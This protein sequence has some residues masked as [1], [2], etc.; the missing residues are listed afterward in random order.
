MSELD[1]RECYRRFQTALTAAYS[2]Y[3]NTPNW[4]EMDYWQE[5]YVNAPLP[6][7]YTDSL[8]GEVTE[9][10]LV[11]CAIEEYQL[12]KYVITDPREEEPWRPPEDLL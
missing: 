12:G 7:P 11:D 8:A 1:A 2:A 3:P 5:K 9:D 4:A 6:D 10:L